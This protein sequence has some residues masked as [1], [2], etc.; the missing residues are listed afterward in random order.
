[1]KFTNREG[2]YKMKKIALVLIFTFGLSAIT[3]SAAQAFLG[4]S[5]CEKL[6]QRSTA[7]GNI[8]RVLWQ[9]YR[10]DSIANDKTT[11]TSLNLQIYQEEVLVLSSYEKILLDMKN[12]QSC[13]S[14]KAN[15]KVRADLQTVQDGKTAVIKL[16]Q[17]VE[18]GNRYWVHTKFSTSMR[19]FV[20][21]YITE[22]G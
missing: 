15:A 17:D 8:G 1:M 20:E 22:M 21:V 16:I 5:K 10:N 6:K 19:Y 3:P 2:L 4:M 12:N 7:E 14:V 18:R 11:G 13:L 9:N